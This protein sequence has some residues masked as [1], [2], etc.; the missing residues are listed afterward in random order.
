M[1]L[2]DRKDMVMLHHAQGIIYRLVTKA[3]LAD[4][5]FQRVIIGYFGCQ[6]YQLKS[7]IFVKVNGLCS[8]GRNHYRT[9]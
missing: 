3:T 5:R 8:S 4:L 1:I 9:S 7:G 6:E 2:M